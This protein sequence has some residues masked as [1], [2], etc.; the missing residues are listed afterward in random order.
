MF[1]NGNAEPAAS[2]MM[3]PET[4]LVGIAT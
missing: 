4:M 1:S 2:G 3:F